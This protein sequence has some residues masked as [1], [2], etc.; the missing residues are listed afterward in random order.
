MFP[1]RD[2]AYIYRTLEF[3]PGN[4]WQIQATVRPTVPRSAFVAPPPLRPL[5]PAANKERRSC[6]K[7]FE[8][9]LTCQ[10]QTRRAPFSIAVHGIHVLGQQQNGHGNSAKIFPE[11][12]SRKRH[13]K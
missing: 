2:P 4:F 13:G 5:L 1:D 10:A 12:I 8:L 7:H 11:K 9:G 3:G 6:R